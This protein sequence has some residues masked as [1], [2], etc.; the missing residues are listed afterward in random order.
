MI[1][2]SP[3]QRLRRAA[4]A[5]RRA[6]LAEC[7][8]P[9]GVL[10]TWVEAQDQALMAQADVAEHQER[11]I[12]HVLGRLER[13]AEAQMTRLSLVLSSAERTDKILARKAEVVAGDMIRTV[14]P[15]LVTGV[16]EALVI[17]EHR[18]NDLMQL[19]RGICVVTCTVSL[20]VSGYVWR[21]GQDREDVALAARLRPA[22]QHCEDTSRWYANGKKACLLED[23]LPPV[24]PPAPP[25]PTTLQLPAPAP[26]PPPPPE[27]APAP[28]SGWQITH[29]GQPVRFH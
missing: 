22:I 15:Q 27:P 2:E 4:W 14:T 20:L 10:G 24:P 3:V 26:Q 13:A 11:L 1:E 21:L 6:A 9:D 8:E 28:S 16:K 23:L 17:R 19:Y 29:P 18:Y 7:I 5:L 25:T 12:T